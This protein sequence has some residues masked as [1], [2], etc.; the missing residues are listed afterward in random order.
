MWNTSSQKSLL[1]LLVIMIFI[2]IISYEYWKYW[3]VP[4]LWI[5]FWWLADCMFLENGMFLYEPNLDYWKEANEEE[6]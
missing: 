2:T 5:F 4:T 1:F 3:F 6:Y